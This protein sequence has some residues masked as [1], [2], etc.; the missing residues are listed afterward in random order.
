MPRACGLR[1]PERKLA[2]A[3]QK[4]LGE[5]VE[6]FFADQHPAGRAGIEGR[7]ELLLGRFKV[8]VAQSDA[9]AV[10][11]QQGGGEKDL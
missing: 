11:A 7:F 4:R 2:V 5:I 1:H 9:D 10:L 3:A 8:D 6:I